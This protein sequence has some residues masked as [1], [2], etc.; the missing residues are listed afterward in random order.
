M[1]SCHKGIQALFKA[2]DGFSANSLVGSGTFG[3]VCKG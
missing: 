1:P 3:M 2:T